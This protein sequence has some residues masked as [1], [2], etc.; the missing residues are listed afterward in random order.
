MFGLAESENSFVVRSDAVIYSNEVFERLK[1]V[2]KSLGE[3]TAD[4]V[5]YRARLRVAK[6]EDDE[7][8]CIRM[9]ALKRL[10]VTANRNLDDVYRT[11]F[12]N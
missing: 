8:F 4:G 11:L 10:A 7:D 2:S 12:A 1:S 3:V 9:I 5:D 6:T